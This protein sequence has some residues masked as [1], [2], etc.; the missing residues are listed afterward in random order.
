MKPPKRCDS[1]DL[2][3]IKDCE[4]KGLPPSDTI[5]RSTGFSSE[6]SGTSVIRFF[7]MF[8][9][10]SFKPASFQRSEKDASDSFKFSHLF[11]CLSNS[12]C[13]FE[14]FIANRFIPY[15]SAIF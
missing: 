11:N 3:S 15:D 10:W 2:S 8:S 7:T 9:I 1:K 14:I 5:K 12:S 6:S 13:W 4:N